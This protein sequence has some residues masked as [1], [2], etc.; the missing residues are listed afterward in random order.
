MFRAFFTH[1]QEVLY[2]QQVVYIFWNEYKKYTNWC[3]YSTS[4]WWVKMCSKHVEAINRNKLEVNNTSCWSY[5]T[6]I[7]RQTV[8]NKKEKKLLVYTF[9]NI[10]IL[11]GLTFWLRDAPTSITFNNCTFCPHC[12]YVFC[13]QQLVPLT[14]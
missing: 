1:H 12:I 9:D 3:T 4:W 6:D 13:K 7:V 2:V 8:S 14:A 11:F 5:Y 10:N